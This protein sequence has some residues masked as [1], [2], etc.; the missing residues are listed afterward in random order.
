MNR[1]RQLTNWLVGAAFCIAGFAG[2]IKAASVDIDIHVSINASKDITAPTSYYYF[3]AININQSSNSVS[4]LQ[5]HNNSSGITETYTI[6]GGTA[7]SDDA[8]TDWN[9]VASSTAISGTETYALA[10]QFSDN[11]NRVANDDEDL[12]QSDYLRIDQYITCTSTVFGD[13]NAARSGANVPPGADRYMYIRIH[14]PAATI[15]GGAHTASIRLSV[16]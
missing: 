13:G 7:T 2:P 9:L 1:H 14:T 8:G 16:L 15:D 10:V 6:K 11:A 5:I 3:G 4:A 12:W